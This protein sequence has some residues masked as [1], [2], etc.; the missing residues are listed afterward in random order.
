MNDRAEKLQYLMSKNLFILNTVRKATFIVKG[1]IGVI[2][3]TVASKEF[4][5]TVRKY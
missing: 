3:M 4:E 2:D 5:L 1:K